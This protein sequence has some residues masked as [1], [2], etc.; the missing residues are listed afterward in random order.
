MPAVAGGRLSALRRRF[1]R[2]TLT[3]F[4]KY[5][6]KSGKADVSSSTPRAPHH[7]AVLLV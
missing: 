3:E 5:I 4:V 6:G 7:P 1:G 2:E